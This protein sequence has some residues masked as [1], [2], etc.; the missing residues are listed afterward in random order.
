MECVFCFNISVWPVFVLWLVGL[1]GVDMGVGTIWRHEQFLKNYNMRRQ[2]GH[3]YDTVMA[4]QMR[5]LCLATHSVYELD[6]ACA[7]SSFPYH[8]QY[9][10]AVN[11]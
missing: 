6:K 8:K 10:T 1:V 4:P 11:Y 3:C 5:C 2:M 9:F 7:C